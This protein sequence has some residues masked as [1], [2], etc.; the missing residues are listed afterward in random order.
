MRCVVSELGVS[1]KKADRRFLS[2]GP[3]TWINARS[4]EKMLNGRV[5]LGNDYIE[6]PAFVCIG[7]GN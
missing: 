3:C 6:N 5:L 2:G 1:K 7:D 4:F